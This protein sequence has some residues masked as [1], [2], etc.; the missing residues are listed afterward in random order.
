MEVGKTCYYHWPLYQNME[1]CWTNHFLFLC[2]LLYL[3]T[4]VCF[5]VVRAGADPPSIL[6]YADVI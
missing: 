6:P 3:F 2:S 5:M 1:K 4:D